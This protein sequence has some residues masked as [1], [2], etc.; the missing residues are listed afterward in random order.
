M[1]GHSFVVALATLS[2][3]SFTVAH[4]GEKH[5]AHIVARDME[6]RS[7]MA[8]NQMKEVRECEGSYDFIGRK[9]RAIKRREATVRRLQEERGLPTNSE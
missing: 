8:E 4:P 1:I 2:S 3:L 5:E 6:L 7:I 9:D